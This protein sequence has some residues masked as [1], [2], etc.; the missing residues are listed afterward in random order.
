MLIKYFKNLSTSFHQIAVFFLNIWITRSLGLGIIG[1]YYYIFIA[2]AALSMIVGARCEIFLFSKQPKEFINHILSSSKL[3]LITGSILFLIFALVSF[4]LETSFFLILPLLAIFVC[5]NEMICLYVFKIKKLYLYSALRLS[6]PFAVFIFFNIYTE[7][8]LVISLALIAQFLFTLFAIKD[9]FSRDVVFSNTFFSNPELK[10]MFIGAFLSIV[11]YSFNFLCIHLLQ[12]KLGNDFVGIWSNIVRIFGAPTSFL[13]AFISPFALRIIDTRNTLGENY[14]EFKK[15]LYLLIPMILVIILFISF[16]GRDTLNLI[17]NTN[18]ELPNYLIILVF[19]SY[20]F[21]MITNLII[22]I[23]QVF[24][25]SFAL[26]TINLIFCLTILLLLSIT[27]LSF[28]NYVLII[29]LMYF[30][31]FLFQIFFLEKQV[32]YSS[33]TR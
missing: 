13:I 28:N 19:L 25:R 21:Q 17:I 24:E 20:L 33:L 12:N 4:F 10:K 14:L 6:Y 31:L 5:F 3:F 18:L 32:K 7:P 15:K 22:P 11:F 8:V 16:F 29:F 26:I 23:F 2:I 9:N 1:E 30:V 27:A